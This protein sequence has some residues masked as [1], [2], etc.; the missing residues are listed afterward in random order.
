MVVIG[1]GLYALELSLSSEAEFNELKMMMASPL[2]KVVIWGSLSAFIYH[3]VAGIKHMIVDFGVG[4]TL[5]GVLFAAR[6]V[7]LVSIILIVLAG[8]WIFQ[9]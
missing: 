6:T 3:F 1:I 9:P 8:V 2:G 5:E 4:E 7:V